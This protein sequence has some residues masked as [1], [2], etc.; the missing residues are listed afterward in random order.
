MGW[1]GFG[2]IF[3]R[4]NSLAARTLARV[5][6]R[7]AIVVLIGAVITSYKVHSGLESEAV[8]GLERYALERR[9]RESQVLLEAEDGVAMF[10]REY[11]AAYLRTADD[12][13]RFS[14]LFAAGE[15]GATRTRPE[16]F[17]SDAV[18]G[19]IGRRVRIDD[20]TRR[21]LLA[22]Y[23][24]LQRFAP[25]WRN[26]F[27]NAYVVTPQNAVLMFWPGRSWAAEGSEW[28]IYGKIDLIQG[29]TSPSA[30]TEDER[31]H[32][33]W[34]RLY[35]DYGMNEWVVSVTQAVWDGDR[36][37]ALVGHDL[38][39]AELIERVVSEDK[40]GIYNLLFDPEGN[41]LAHPRFMEA[42]QASGGALPVRETEDEHLKAVFQ[43]AARLAPTSGIAELIGHNEIIAASVLNGTGWYLVTIFPKAII[44]SQA[45]WIGWLVLALGFGALLI[46]LSI[47]STMLSRHV[48]EP[49]AALVRTADKLR[50]GRSEA[51]GALTEL[52]PER[53]DELG[54]LSRAFRGM[55]RALE[56]READLSSGNAELTRLAAELRREL[57]ERERA[58]SE[59]ARQRDFEAL[60][61]SVDHG[62]LFLD[63][64]L[65]VRTA[66]PAYRRIWQTPADFYDV[67]RTLR[68]DMEQ[69]R[70]QGLYIQSDEVWPAWREKRI[71]R[72]KAGDIP[73]YELELSNGT[74]LEYQCIALPDGGRML[75]YYDITALKNSASRLR[76][77]L[78]G[79]EASMDGMALADSAG[80]YRWVNESH[81]RVYGFAREEMIGISWTELYDQ[82]ELK[83]FQED[84]MPALSSARTWRGEATGRRSDGSL[85]PQDLSLS[86][87]EDGGIVCV[88]RDVTERKTRERA[89][90]RALAEAE[91]SNAAKSRFLAA[92]SHEL[93]T[94]LN[95]V[96]GFARIV[97]R[98]TEGMIPQ[99]QAENLEKIQ[100]SGEHLL[101]LIN[102][103]LDLSKIEAGRMDVAVAPY[104]PAGIVEEC[105]RTIEPMV[106]TGVKLVSE[107]DAAPPE[108]IGDAAKLRQILT[109]LLSNAA[110]HTEQGQITVTAASHKGNL[111][112]TVAD[113]GPGIPEEFRGLIFEEFG[114]VGGPH[115]R[116]SGGTGLGLTIS[117]RLARL[118]GGD[119][120]VRSTVGAGSTFIVDLPLQMRGAVDDVVEVAS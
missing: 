2:T 48:G 87:T 37:V 54:T 119:L 17:E 86:V 60:L 15:N 112:L 67:P 72:V 76:T 9:A 70:N 101:K 78:H 68:D 32:P 12:G 115:G 85:F 111:R 1:A 34:S 59:L 89:L 52:D 51:E 80:C 109:N 105:M 107:I 39:L 83:R 27:A 31:D 25:A 55:A 79:M 66:N 53:P 117:R 6:T 91:S 82:S 24:V 77:F 93:R 56:K 118:M 103:I 36:Y 50:L 29:G 116:P 43:S 65:N 45:Q 69:S 42:I 49:L 62:V 104:S 90:D 21:T 3:P 4:R 57:A 40:S 20:D 5:A 100:L 84:I 114:Q 38:L 14:A 95:A 94:P 75:T 26:R 22:G 16:V 88:V 46:E 102:E 98:K 64:N 19:F 44:N 23:E 41:L 18:S 63:A 96:I 108:A 30:A 35:F 7:I 113:T 92:M 33:H 8:A 71:E 106:A 110:R 99:R 11:R 58:E 120:R 47:L 10:A 73:A 97:H 28:G 74:V 81:A 13:D 61:N